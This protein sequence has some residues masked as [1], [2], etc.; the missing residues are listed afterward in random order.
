VQSG[1]SRRNSTAAS[2]ATPR[3]TPRLSRRNLSPL[4]GLEADDAESLSFASLN[5]SAALKKRRSS[6]ADLEKNSSNINSR[7]RM[8]EAK[9][10]KIEHEL[11]LGLKK[12][13]ASMPHNSVLRTQ[14]ISSLVEHASLKQREL[15]ELLGVSAATV[16]RAAASSARNALEMHRKLDA[17]AAP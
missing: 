17:S 12:T 7:K 3:T 11:V 9:V 2:S 10:S 4:N 16:S 13:I 14:L 1:A 6:A 8:K 15:S 5:S